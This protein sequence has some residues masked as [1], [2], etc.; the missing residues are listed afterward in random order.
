MSELGRVL[1]LDAR[2][3]ALLV[4]VPLLTG[5][6]IV[7][8]W[9]SLVPG[10]AYWDNSIVALI[11]SVRLLGPVAAGLAAWAA[12]RERG[13]NYL[14]D[15]SPRSPA[16]GALLDL[17]LLAGAAA[18]AYAA[19]TAVVTV[20]TVVRNGAG[21]PHPL[22]VL[23]GLTALV[24]HVVAGY[25]AARVAPRPATAVTVMA[26]AWLWA[27][28]RAPGASWWSLLPPAALDHVELFTGLRAGVLAD[29]ALWA[30]GGTAVLI[31]AYVGRVTRRAAVAVPLAGALAV[32]AVAT[33]R[34]ESSG[35]DA[36]GPA[37][38]GPACRE[39]PLRICVHPAL[40]SALPALM[41]E[42]TPLA[43]RLSGTPGEFTRVVQR[44]VTEPPRVAG[45]TAVIHLDD[46]LA[47]GY[48]VRAV[49]QITNALGGSRI[50]ATSRYADYRAL[51]DA[52]LLGREAPAIPDA[53][54]ADRFG[55]WTEDQRREWL[56]VNFTRY[57][58]CALSPGDF[59]PVVAPAPADA[60]RPSPRPVLPRDTPA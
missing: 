11:N 5:I 59:R 4:A 27:A 37:P 3:A 47:P 29:Q 17:L 25:L 15:L 38:A 42:A 54:T 53:R 33:Y 35:G 20:E 1:R 22:G 8:V 39:W 45:G 34:L 16:T 24:L 43:T 44:P 49:R 21:R 30:L 60:P 40:R 13:L 55:Q 12:V 2:R 9:L 48:E 32:T 58:D 57:R 18:L 7:T 26:V 23:A 52:W 19:V 46:E 50:C 6:G 14:R 28:V 56:R 31:L 51:V 10:V 41:A 36:I